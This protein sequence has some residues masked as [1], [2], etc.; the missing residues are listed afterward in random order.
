MARILVRILNRRILHYYLSYC[1]YT[2]YINIGAFPPRVM[3]RRIL[4]PVM[5]YQIQFDSTGLNEEAVFELA[6]NGRHMLF[7]IL[8]SD[9][10]SD[11]DLEN[12]VKLIEYFSKIPW[13]EFEDLVRK[14]KQC[15]LYF[16]EL[17]TDSIGSI[18]IL[19]LAD[20][21]IRWIEV[22]FAMCSTMPQILIILTCFRAEMRRL[23]V[24]SFVGKSVNQILMEL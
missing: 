5:N 1:K 3:A 8:H 11:W 4:N 17:H 22:C 6:E 24:D 13:I 23:G 10:H 2:V 12:P 16:S 9:L 20:A 7:H 15:M 21:Q 14:A 19:P 18:K